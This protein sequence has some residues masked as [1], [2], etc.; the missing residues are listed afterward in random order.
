MHHV[1]GSVPS[2]PVT[3]QHKFQTV[4]SP[5]PMLHR[6]SHSEVILHWQSVHNSHAV[7]CEMK[8]PAF[9]SIIKRRLQ[10]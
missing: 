10:V 3:G 1:L 8:L 7:G 4:P 9:C 6:G 2:L 5:E